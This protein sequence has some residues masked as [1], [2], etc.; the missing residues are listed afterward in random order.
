LA[1]SARNFSW[2]ESATS[3]KPA[4]STAALGAGTSAAVKAGLAVLSASASD[5]A[6]APRTAASRIAP[7]DGRGGAGPPANGARKASAR[8]SGGGAAGL[9]EGR[10]RPM[11]RAAALE[12][13]AQSRR[14]LLIC[15][16][17]G[18]C[19][20]KVIPTTHP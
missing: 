7:M 1:R 3:E 5:D 18:W 6:M 17:V 20:G 19:P 14:M 11:F 16:Y 10:P 4:R 9:G 2:S 8:R 15:V 12:R 13:S